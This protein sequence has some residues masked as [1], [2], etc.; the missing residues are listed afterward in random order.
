[1]GKIHPGLPDEDLLAMAPEARD[2]ALQ[3][4]VDWYKSEPRLPDGT[5]VSAVRAGVINTPTATAF[6]ELESRVQAANEMAAAAE[7]RANQLN[8]GNQAVVIALQTQAAAAT[9]AAEVANRTL[10]ERTAAMKAEA[11]K[12]AVEFQAEAGRL[13]TE[14]AQKSAAEIAR[15]S[16]LAG[17]AVTS[18]QSAEAARKAAEKAELDRLNRMGNDPGYT[19]TATAPAEDNTPL[20]LTA[21]SIAISLLT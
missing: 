4:V 5:P 14:A 11:E 19:A 6:N 10:A 2:S 13:M 16:D 3:A 8:T 21:V 20:L 17:K 12:Q 7:A 18:I 9:Q 1:M 15:L